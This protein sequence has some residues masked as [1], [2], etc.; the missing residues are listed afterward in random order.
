MDTMNTQDLGLMGEIHTDLALEAREMFTQRGQGQEP[1]GVGTETER[2][3]D[4]VITR[5]HIQTEAAGRVMNKVPGYYVTL[6]APGLRTTDRD[7]H[8]EIAFLTAKEIE[9]FVG[10]IGVKEEDTCL[11]IGLGNWDATPDALGP[12]V[13]G[14]ILVTR[15]LTEMTPP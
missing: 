3:G 12:K 13:V 2:Q 5:V 1:P 9:G 15:H 6:E 14:D 7:K 11:I 8:E 10:R 4:T